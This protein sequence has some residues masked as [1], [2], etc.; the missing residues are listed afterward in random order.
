[1]NEPD[2]NYVYNQLCKLKMIYHLGKK[3]LIGRNNFWLM[4]I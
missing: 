4:M 2:Y 1:M 3:S